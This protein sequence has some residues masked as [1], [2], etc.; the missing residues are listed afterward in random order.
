MNDLTPEELM[1]IRKI[2]ASEIRMHLLLST[3]R[4]WSVWIVAVIT[5]VTVGY[6]TLVDVIKGAVK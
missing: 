1:Y 5:G 2:I 6:Q 4:N 3:I